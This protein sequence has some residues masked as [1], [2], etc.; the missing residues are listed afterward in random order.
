MTT[1]DTLQDLLVR[2]YGLPRER[3]VPEAPLDTL[4]MDSLGML[5]L[6]F[7]I[8]DNFKVRIPG[9]APTNLRT[10]QDVVAYVDGLIAQRPATAQPLSAAKGA[11]S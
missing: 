3:L 9:D 8:E 11:A 6:M 2:D 7:K 1:L 5:E 4:G 10:V